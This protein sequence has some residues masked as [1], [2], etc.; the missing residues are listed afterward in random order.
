MYIGIFNDDLV[1]FTNTASQ[2][3]LGHLFLYYVSI[4][5]VD[6]KQNFENMRKSWDP[7]QPVETLFKLTSQRPERMHLQRR[8]NFLLPNPKIS[9][10]GN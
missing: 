3:M 10:Q 2:D 6:I 1:G 8:K 4:T 5:A 9:S 7:Q